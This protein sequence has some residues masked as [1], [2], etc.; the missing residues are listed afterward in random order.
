[1]ASLHWVVAVQHSAA[2]PHKEL[3][4]LWVLYDPGASGYFF[5]AVFEMEGT[6]QFLKGYEARMAEGDVLHV[7]THPPGMFLLA[8]SCISVCEHSE[9]VRNLVD[10]VTASTTTEAFRFVE[11]NA[12]LQRP[13]KDSELSALQLLSLVTLLLAVFAII[14]LALVS[15]RLFNSS[16]AWL[17]CCLWPTVPTISV[18]FPKSDLLFPALSLLLLLCAITGCRS[19]LRAIFIGLPAGAVL[20]IAA[21]LSLAILPT[22][23]AI[24]VFLLMIVIGRPQIYGKP[25]ITLVLCVSGTFG[26]LTLLFDQLYHCNLVAVFQ[27]NFENHAGFYEQFQR[28]WWKWLLVN[29]IELAFAVGLPVFTIALWATSQIRSGFTCDSHGVEGNTNDLMEMQN[30][31]KPLLIG[32]AITVALLWLSGKNNGEAARLWCFMT[33]WILLLAGPKLQ[34]WLESQAGKNRRSA[35]TWLLATQLIICLMTVSRVSGFSF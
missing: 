32:L 14:P 2:S 24:A 29:P 16:T 35:V 33:P 4:P 23:A 6:D 11:Q 31:T 3:K 5:E 22:V 12:A 1:M 13:L 34:H 9:L 21:S 26:L 15:N 18:F 17:I 28:T 27:A 7:G 20:L 30:F 25:V 8:K 19:T 10:L